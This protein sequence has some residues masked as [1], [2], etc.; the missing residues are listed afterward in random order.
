MGGLGN[1]KISTVWNRGS[2]E[3]P[4]RKPFGE[5]QMYEMKNKCYITNEYIDYFWVE[6]TH[7]WESC[8]KD[9]VFQSTFKSCFDN[10]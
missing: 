2:M 1:W 3:V 4:H 9:P 7:K 10:C 6:Q 8:R 5:S